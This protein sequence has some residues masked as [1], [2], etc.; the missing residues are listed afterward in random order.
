[1]ASGGR[2]ARSFPPA[3]L[4]KAYEHHVGKVLSTCSYTKNSLLTALVSC[5]ARVVRCQYDSFLLL[6]LASCHE[7]LIMKLVSQ[8]LVGRVVGPSSVSS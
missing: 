3:A 6:Q 4:D 2:L 5:K 8:S 1:M 7:N